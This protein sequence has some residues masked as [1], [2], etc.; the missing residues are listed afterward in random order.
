MSAPN[1]TRCVGAREARRIAD[2]HPGAEDRGLC[3]VHFQRD[4]ALWSDAILDADE[5]ARMQNETVDP[6]GHHVS[7]T[8]GPCDRAGHSVHGRDPPRVV[9]YKQPPTVGCRSDA[10]WR[11]QRAGTDERIERLSALTN[12]VDHC[13]LPVGNEEISVGAHRDIAGFVGGPSRGNSNRLTSAPVP[14]SYCSTA[15][16]PESARLPPTVTGD[17]SVVT[18]RRSRGASWQP[19][20]LPMPHPARDR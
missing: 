4:H 18:H 1:A 9:G 3:V 14:S 19:P 15:A 16:R 12:H 13:R 20:T 7:R 11:D 10:L 8:N 5:R 6:V 2:E 17:H